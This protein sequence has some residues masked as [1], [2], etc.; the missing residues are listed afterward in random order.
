M[1]AKENRWIPPL[2]KKPPTPEIPC[3]AEAALS[4]PM[5][6]RGKSL[7]ALPPHPQEKKRHGRFIRARLKKGHDRED[8]EKFRGG[9]RPPSTDDVS[10]EGGLR[11][12]R[13]G[14]GPALG[15]DVPRE[16][17]PASGN[18]AGVPG[19]RRMLQ[20]KFLPS[21]KK[22][23]FFNLAGR[24][25]FRNR[26]DLPGPLSPRAIPDRIEGREDD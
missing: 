16:G 12:V 19:P 10:R 2:R 26:P 7:P 25:F 20:E 5:R 9:K 15:D 13:C 21:R 8:S 24:P 6:P 22:F 3:R 11:L 23:S 1:A 17:S 14:H 4:F 18:P